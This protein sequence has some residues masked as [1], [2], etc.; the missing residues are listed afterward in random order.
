[1]VSVGEVLRLVA[2]V[3]HLE[4]DQDELAL[5][6]GTEVL[7]AH[8]F[9]SGLDLADHELERAVRS[10]IADAGAS[11]GLLRRCAG[12][13]VASLLSVRALRTLLLRGATGRGRVLVA[14]SAERGDTHDQGNDR[15]HAGKD[16]VPREPTA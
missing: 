2:G 1:L 15:H 12:E 7:I 13:L 16:L 9:H 3:R 8:G 6:L 14:A 5:R 11:V 4:V 10:R